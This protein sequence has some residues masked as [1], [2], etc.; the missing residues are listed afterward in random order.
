[1]VVTAR[2]DCDLL[3]GVRSLLLGLTSTVA[4]LGAAAG[5][6]AATFA[7]GPCPVAAPPLTALNGARCGFLTVP[8]HRDRPDGRTIRLRVAI[9]PARSK[10]RAPDPVVYLTGGPGGSAI[11]AAQNVVNAGANR[12][13]DLIV[14]EQRGT[15]YSDPSLTCPV[16]DRWN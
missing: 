14:L 9:T 2:S 5:A 3:R 6:E 12:D 10:P 4:A 1:M 8:E 11:S 7:S 16:I 13:R 15:L